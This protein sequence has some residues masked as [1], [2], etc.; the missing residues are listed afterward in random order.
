MVT[1]KWT[2][3]DTIVDEESEVEVPEVL[4]VLCDIGRY[5][6]RVVRNERNS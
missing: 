1:E 4:G 5:Y 2:I 3:P 6:L